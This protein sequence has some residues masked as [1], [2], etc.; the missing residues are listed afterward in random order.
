MRLGLPFV[1]ALFLFLVPRLYF[2]QQYED[3]CRPDG[4]QEDDYWEFQR[5]TLPTILSKLSWL[6]YLPALFIDTILTY[7]LLAWTIR[8]SRKIPFNA[9][10]DGA[11]IFGQIVVF[12]L[13]LFP[14]FYLDTYF[15]R[16]M[17]KL[18]PSTL[19]L[20]GVFFVYYTAQLAINTK[21]GDKYAMLI[22]LVGPIGSICLN[23][24]KDQQANE[25]LHHVLM[26][27]NYDAIFFSQGV[28]DQLYFKPMM[29][30]RM[31]LAKTLWAPFSLIFGIL[32]YALAS[33]Q[34]YSDTGFLFFYPLYSDYT[35]QS[36]YTSGTWLW[37]FF[38]AWLMQLVGN[39]KFNLIIYKYF[40]GNAL[41]AYLCH[42]LIIILI[43]VLIIRPY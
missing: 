11:I 20:I 17:E 33:P 43:A 29:R 21:H 7:P 16:G 2:G 25:P 23:V 27:I 19:T 8:R 39:Q 40:V 42:Y 14:C 12:T 24:W 4:V 28:T 15:N 36:F 10:D 22:K 41:Y 37:L 34:N 32:I 6:W 35:I 5:K 18:F 9:R 26:M 3:W 31:K 13:W 1:A 30:Y 38:L